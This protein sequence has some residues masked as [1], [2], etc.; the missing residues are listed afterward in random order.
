MH[1]HPS[2]F[3]SPFNFLQ[4][5]YTQGRKVIIWVFSFFG[6]SIT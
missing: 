5:I 6:Y 3:L 2:I 1:T 4:L